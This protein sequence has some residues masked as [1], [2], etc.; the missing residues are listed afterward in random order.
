MK[1]SLK[2]MLAA[3]LAFVM[4]VNLTPITSFAFDNSSKTQTSNS[5][6][7]ALE[8]PL[9]EIIDETKRPISENLKKTISETDNYKDLSKTEKANL[10]QYLTVSED[11]FDLLGKQVK[12]VSDL[13]TIVLHAENSGISVQTVE[14]LLDKFDTEECINIEQ[15]FD[16]LAENI[17][18]IN[19]VDDYAQLL[20]EDS[21]ELN[22]L[23]GVMLLSE[24]TG[25]N[26]T[27][28]FQQSD[29]HNIDVNKLPDQNKEEFITLQLNYNLSADAINAVLSEHKMSAP[30]LLSAIEEKQKSQNLY[31]LNSDVSTNDVSTQ[32]IP[33]GFSKY[34]I[35]ETSN[36]RNDVAIDQIYGLITYNKELLSLKGKNNLDLNF[37]LRYDQND[38]VLPGNYRY[39]ENTPRIYQVIYNTDAYILDNNGLHLYQKNLERYSEYYFNSSEHQK[40]VDVKVITENVSSSKTYYYYVNSAQI[41]SN[42]I[43]IDSDGKYETTHNNKR[44]NLGE[45]WA[46]SLPSIELF[47]FDYNYDVSNVLHFADGQ[48]YSFRKNNPSDKNY[49]IIG[50]DFKDIQLLDANANEF[51][52]DGKTAK[53][54][55]TYKDGRCEYFAEDGRYIGTTDKRGNTATASIQ[56]FYDN[57]GHLIKL[58][59]SVGRS[60]KINHHINVYTDPDIGTYTE[61]YTDIELCEPNTQE[62]K[63]LYRLDKFQD[64]TSNGIPLLSIVNTM[65]GEE[66][67]KSTRYTYRALENALFINGGG[68]VILDMETGEMLFSP[69][70]IAN[71]GVTILTDIYDYSYSDPTQECA[72]LKLQ[73]EIAKR[74][75][76]NASTVIYRRIKE[77]ENLVTR[78]DENF[79]LIETAKNKEIYKYYSENKSTKKREDIEYNGAWNTS[80]DKF[81]PIEKT[82]DFVLEVQE[83]FEGDQAKKLTEYHYGDNKYN[84][85]ISIYELNGTNKKLYCYND[86]QR[87]NNNHDIIETVRLAGEDGQFLCTVNKQNLDDYA[88]TEYEWIASGQSEGLNPVMVSYTISA[89]EAKYDGTNKSIPTYISEELLSDEA[90]IHYQAL[91]TENTLDST[92]SYIIKQ[93]RYITDSKMNW[94]TLETEESKTLVDSVEYTY[95]SDNQ[96]VATDQS[97][98]SGNKTDHK[99]TEYTYDEKYGIYPATVTEVDAIYTADDN[100]QDSVTSFTYDMQGR[101]LTS[102][103]NT[104]DHTTSYEYDALGTLVKSTSPNGAQSTTNIDYNNKIVI[105]T[106][107]NGMSLKY[108]YDDW[109]QLAAEYIWSPNADD[110]ILAVKYEYDENSRN[111]K[112]YEYSSTDA[113]QYTCTTYKY[114][115]LDRVIRETVT[116]EKGNV[117]SDVGTQV[118]IIL[119]GNALCEKTLTTYFD[120]SG[121]ESSHVIEY[122]DSAGNTYRV[123]TEYAAGNYYQDNYVYG[124]YNRLLSTSGDTIEDLDYTYDDLG[125]VAEI[126]DAGGNSVYYEYDS[127]NRLTKQSNTF[128]AVEKYLYT[129]HNYQYETDKLIDEVTDTE[130]YSKS[131]SGYDV[132]GNIVQVKNTNNAIGANEDFSTSRYTY[133]VNN[134]MIMTEDVL[135][136]SRSRYTQYCYNEADQVT[137]VFTG[138]T[139]PLTITDESTYSANEDKNFS[140]QSYEYDLNGNLTKYTDALGK[141]D[142]YTYSFANLLTKIT[143][144]NGSVIQYE[145][146][147]LGRCLKQ[148]SADQQVT[149]TYNNIG[150]LSSM[151]D[152]LGTVNYQ[153]DLLNR[154]TKE[155]RDDSDNDRDYTAE[156][157]YNGTGITDYKL[158]VRN[159]TS[160]A[161]QNVIHETYEYNNLKQL[162]KFTHSDV[163]APQ[164]ILTTSYTYGTGGELLTKHVSGSSVNQ[165]INYTYNPGG[166]NT[167]ITNTN[168]LAD[169][170]ANN[171]YPESVTYTENYSYNLNGT[172]SEKNSIQKA[173][174]SGNTVLDTNEQIAYVYDDLGRLTNEKHVQKGANADQITSNIA[175]ALDES[176]NRTGYEASNSSIS[177]QYDAANR[178]IQKS[179]I[180][181]GTT[182]YTY[183]NS[184]NLLSETTTNEKNDSSTTK[185]YTYDSFN[186]LSSVQVDE[187]TYSYLYDG[188]DQRI[189]KNVSNSQLR[190]FWYNGKIVLE[191]QHTEQIDSNYLTY[192]HDA[193]LLAVSSP[194]KRVSLSVTNAHGDTIGLLSADNSYE[195]KYAYDAYGNQLSENTPDVQNPYQYNGKYLDSETG[196][197]Y[198]NARYYNP[199]IGRFMQEDTYHGSVGNASTANL[200]NYCGSNPISYEDGTGH[201][202]ET[203]LDVVSIAWSAYDFIKKPNLLNGISLAWDVAA[204]VIPCVPGS[205]VGKA[206]KAVT[207]GAKAAKAISKVSK[208][209]KA[210]DK[211]H[212]ALKAIDKATDTIKA[213][214]RAKKVAKS[215]ISAAEQAARKTKLIR[216]AAQ[217]KVNKLLTAAKAKATSR[218]KQLAS[219]LAEMSNNTVSTV[220]Y[221]RPSGYRKGVRETVWEQAKAQGGGIVRDPLTGQ[222]IHFEDAWDMGHK[223]GYEFRKH[224]MSAQR[225]GITRKQFLDEYNNPNHYRP[226]LPSSNRS[227][228]LEDASTRYLGP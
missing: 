70:T 114:D 105:D 99:I 107:P 224:Q 174:Q 115:F 80:R 179:E 118:N 190:E 189:Q 15:K 119:D 154:I 19:D 38:A 222:E 149:F 54:V 58:I 213:V 193:D 117:L 122:N 111:T 45:G 139:D 208:I 221:K 217:K 86:I 146:D 216:E 180:D 199:E 18:E 191:D 177:Y 185:N 158:S 20:K 56:A 3:I 72:H 201:F 76:S 206:V 47:T 157:A 75:I 121:N 103:N 181:K 101:V 31:S 155:S 196:F 100:L 69:K 104:A 205:Y 93:D 46:F 131:I 138:L 188:N 152:D 95:N 17:I 109:N 170:S 48:K 165:S 150:Q 184:G 106:L 50:Y 49:E 134:R 194:D 8:Q 51:T 144:R 120:T 176:D 164:E 13:T 212:D 113:S 62:G 148:S 2:K 29:I 198:L 210:I 23:Y 39:L 160:N 30:Q 162:T 161:F 110:Y 173:V 37:S 9:A 34:Q 42:D 67:V 183:D 73:Y 211:A 219:D 32:E 159:R 175:Y 77:I 218:N 137:K 25:S 168:I 128:G 92:N 61:Y 142:S 36:Y 59:D 57:D 5:E 28:A 195:A 66:I 108:T 133:D 166:L 14:K 156:Y 11:E 27:W 35:P 163:T 192:T 24:I 204:A 182:T 171:N 98:Q 203:A 44:Y 223:P 7:I 169:S 78:Y 130:Y 124:N 33:H 6:Q 151:E 10:C 65:D 52:C 82:N 102:Q 143:L 135:D 68:G 129:P 84:D 91:R 79:N 214:K 145:Y 215:A 172:L 220:S 178:L 43:A 200:Y 88:N 96:L 116:D 60:I 123:D 4:V 228:R 63:I 1:Q 74:Y 55:L 71:L 97:I 90:D 64:G 112:K 186:R 197:Y 125:R 132:Y 53:W 26:C 22:D 85:L 136:N 225:R 21:V 147:A 141:S 89:T 209:V 207:K 83:N 126:R 167:Q 41:N 94:E 202:W 127:Q 87:N 153:Y 12:D 40:Y 140:T 81:W 226:E 227:H 16:Y 187:E